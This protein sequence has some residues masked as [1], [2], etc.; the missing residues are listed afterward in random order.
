[1]HSGAVLKGIR[2][3]GFNSLSKQIHGVASGGGIIE[4]PVSKIKEIEDAGQTEFTGV[5]YWS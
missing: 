1:M 4:I 2:A 5:K 3:T